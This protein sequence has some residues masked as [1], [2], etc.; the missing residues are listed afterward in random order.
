M[1]IVPKNNLIAYEIFYKIEVG[2]REFMI[3]TFGKDDPKWWKIRI[4]SDILLK[5]R[6]GREKEK[7]IKWVELIPHHPIYYIDFPDL[8]KIIEIDDNWKGAFQNLLGDKDVYCGGLR[9]LEPIRNKIAHNRRM[10]DNE[11]YI[12]QANHSKLENAVGK[13]LWEIVN[14]VS[15]YRTEHLRKNSNI[16]DSTEVIYGLMSECKPIVNLI[17]WAQISNEWWFDSDYLFNDL[18]TIV[19]FYELANR[20]I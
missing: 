13:Q 11:V 12:L 20:Y 5:L 7:K 1:S 16:K 3:S 15:N 2:L 6:D 17:V 19:R 18:S 8:K 14:K 4:P 10:S 9:E